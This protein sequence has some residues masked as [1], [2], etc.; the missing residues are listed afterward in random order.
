MED[1]E[2]IAYLEEYIDDLGAADKDEELARLLQDFEE[3]L[4][5]EMTEKNL[6]IEWISAHLEEPPYDSDDTNQ[7]KKK[8]FANKEDY[9]RRLKILL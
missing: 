1:A 8:Q 4:Q 9:T 2:K 6:K 7:S 5:T 3:K